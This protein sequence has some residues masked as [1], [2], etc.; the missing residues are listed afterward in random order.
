MIKLFNSISVCFVCAFVSVWSHV[1]VVVEKL[2]WSEEE[3]NGER[4]KNKVNKDGEDIREREKHI[5]QQSSMNGD[6][7]VYI[8]PLL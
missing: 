8:I 5:I 2:E 4:E 6:L 7:F 3:E 1:G